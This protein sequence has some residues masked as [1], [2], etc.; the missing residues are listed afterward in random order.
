MPRISTKLWVSRRAS[1]QHAREQSRSGLSW[2]C[3]DC[4]Q[5]TERTSMTVFGKPPSAYFHFSKGVTL[6]ILA[7]GIARFIVGSKLL[8]M[9]GAVLL[10]VI[11]LAIRIHL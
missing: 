6:I 9:N 1:L 8:T 4:L 2:S 3:P 5:Q 10:G 7:I 11:Y